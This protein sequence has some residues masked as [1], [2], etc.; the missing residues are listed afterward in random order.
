M[1]TDFLIYL[2]FFAYI[3]LQSSIRIHF[4]ILIKRLQVFKSDIILSS[5]FFF[6]FFLSPSSILPSSHTQITIPCPSHL[7]LDLQIYKDHPKLL[8]D[9]CPLS[10]NVVLF[11]DYYFTLRYLHNSWF[12]LP[13]KKKCFLTF[14][15]LYLYLLYS[16]VTTAFYCSVIQ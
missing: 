16:Y 2:F 7:I 14:L 11:V 3:C 6:F 10:K 1:Y 5:Y 15:L 12:F 9:F 8:T 13:H 4:D